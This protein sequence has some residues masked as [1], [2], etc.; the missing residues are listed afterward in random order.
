MQ[1]E[2]SFIKPNKNVLVPPFI[3]LSEVCDPNKCDKINEKNQ[4]KFESE[5]YL[6]LTNHQTQCNIN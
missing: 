2:F 6:S 5:K 1:L 3:V 4:Q